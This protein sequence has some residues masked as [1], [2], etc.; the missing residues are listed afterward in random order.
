MHGRMLSIYA[1][2]LFSTWQHRTMRSKFYYHEYRY[3][4]PVMTSGFA[5]LVCSNIIYRFCVK[6]RLICSVRAYSSRRP[7]HSVQNILRQK[8][9]RQSVEQNVARRH[10]IARGRVSRQ[11]GGRGL[12]SETTESSIKPLNQFIRSC[13]SD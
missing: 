8:I 12:H 7:E 2:V 5:L 13:H 9:R 10:C 1:S 11:A 3:K 4:R 6:N